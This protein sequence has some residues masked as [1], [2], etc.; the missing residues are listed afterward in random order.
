MAISNNNNFIM[1]ASA[2]ESLIKW[3]LEGDILKRF[4]GHSGTV[5]SVA[6]SNNNNFI[7]SA[8]A[9]KSLIKWDLEGNI[10]KRFDGHL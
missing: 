5:W 9:D 10:L 7:M 1:S 6:I 4:K 3:N 2:D 8:S